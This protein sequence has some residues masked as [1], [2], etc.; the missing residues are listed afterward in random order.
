MVRKR[1]ENIEGR[2]EKAALGC[3]RDPKDVRLVAV[4]KTF[5]AEAVMEATRDALGQSINI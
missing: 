5:P 2:M 4:S 1:L 3:G